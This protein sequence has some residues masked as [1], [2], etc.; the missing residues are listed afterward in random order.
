MPPS[1]AKQKQ[2]ERYNAVAVQVARGRDGYKPA[3]KSRYSKSASN[4][5]TFPITFA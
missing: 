4:K 5:F 2:H 3:V 1:Q